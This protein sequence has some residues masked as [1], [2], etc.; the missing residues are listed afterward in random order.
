MK[1]TLACLGISLGLAASAQAMQPT[2]PVQNQLYACLLPPA[3][4]H[5]AAAVV[6]GTASRPSPAGACCAAGERCSE[7]LSIEPLSIDRATPRT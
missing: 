5:H 4:I 1:I 2:A 6:G 7:L 3:A